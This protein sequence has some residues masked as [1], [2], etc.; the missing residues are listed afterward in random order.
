[1][2][3]DIVPIQA[4]YLFLGRPWQYD[5]RVIHDRL[6]NIYF[7][8][9]VYDIVSIQANYLLLGRP[10]Q[11]DIRA[12]HDRLI[13]KY[14]FEMDERPII[15]YLWHLN[16]YIMSDGKGDWKGELVY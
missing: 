15:L 14:S 6:T 3:Y 10:W 2:V 7:F 16:K 11:Y 9:V 4:N 5:I 8:K 12:M 13:N 1:M